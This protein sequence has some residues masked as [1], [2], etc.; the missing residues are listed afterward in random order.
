MQEQS[1][2]DEGDSYNTDSVV[3][4]YNITFED[5]FH[6]VESARKSQKKYSEQKGDGNIMCCTIEVY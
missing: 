4:V 6:C 2:E 3:S 1:L 5:L